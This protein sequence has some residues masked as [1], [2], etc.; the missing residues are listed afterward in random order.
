MEKDMQL[1]EVEQMLTDCRLFFETNQTLDY[2]FRVVQLKKLRKAIQENEENLMNALQ[3]DL[4]KHPFESYA[5]EIGFILQSITYTLKNLSKWMKVKKVRSPLALYP[6]K[7]F[8]RHEPY[9][10]VLIIGP[11]N[12]PLQLLIE[13]LIGAIAAGNCAVLKPSE[14]VP[15]TS[16]AVA[17]MISATFEP[18]FVRAVEGGVET[19]KA[20]LQGRF[21]NIF[22]TGSPAVG[23]LVMKAAAENLIP[24]TLELGGKSP[25]FVD[26]SADIQLAANRIVW[27]KTVNAGQ[28][29]VAPDYVVVHESIKEKLIEEMKAAIGRFYGESVEKSEYFGRI[30]N[31][32]HFA[33][34][35]KIIEAEE[36]NILYG[37]KS[38]AEQHFLE[39]ALIQADWES[40]SMEDEIFGP[41]L[42]IIGYTDKQDVV[43]KVTKMTKPLAMYI[44]TASKEMEEY[45]LKSISSGGVS[46]NDTLTHLA[47]PALPFGGIGT[48]GMG[49]YH[50]IYSFA[51]F[52]HKRSVL[53]RGKGLKFTELF[54]P[55]TDKKLALVRRFLK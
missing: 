47:N 32:R 43:K 46:I 25:A 15:A 29:C 41:I 26:E 30:V 38:K 48:S 5:T 12:Y 3:T 16:K 6:A 39:P 9:G 18:A 10:T 22:F 8:I 13:P 28:T 33:R 23:K 52:S 4:G 14:L 55:Y 1:N 40:P 37:G 36:G 42:P 31:D 49:S 51:A 2:Q 24:V 45:W 21:D 50:G 17:S 35:V 19:N 54:P 53:K 44:F 11:F 34:L 20:L 27:G 7:S